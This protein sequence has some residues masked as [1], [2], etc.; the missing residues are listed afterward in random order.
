[1]H[2]FRL[3]GNFIRMPEATHKD[4]WSYLVH[5][6]SLLPV[7]QSDFSKLSSCNSQC[8]YPI[9]SSSQSLVAALALDCGQIA[10]LLQRPSVYRYTFDLLY[11]VLLRYYFSTPL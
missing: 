10:A 8:G 2:Q 11:L 7:S 1:M 9:W 3:L 5:V 6:L 4:I